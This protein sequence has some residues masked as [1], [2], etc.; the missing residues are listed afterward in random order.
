AVEALC[1]S[2][3]AVWALHPVLVATYAAD[4]GRTHLLS[5]TFSILALQAHLRGL[6]ARR[7]AGWFTA[8]VLLLAAAMLC[9]PI[10][11]W[12][13]VATGFHWLR[14]GPRAALTAPSTYVYL[15]IC[16]AFGWLT[17]ATSRESGL[18]EDVGLALSGDPLT[19]SLL[20]A[21]LYV[22]HIFRP[23]NLAT[24]YPPDIHTGWRHPL[25]WVGAAVVGASAAVVVLT[26][27]TERFRGVAVG[28]LWYWALLAPMLGFVGA[29]LAAAQDRYL[30]QPLIGALFAFGAAIAGWMRS[31]HCAR[32]A[33]RIWT[34]SG[35]LT[36]IALLLIPISREYAGDARGALR[37]AERVREIFPSDPRCE[38][39]LATAYMFAA[40]HP[41]GRSDA[42][43]LR[44]QAH[45]ALLRAGE[46]ADEHPE[47]FA[48]ATHRAWF[49]RDVS[50]R[51]Q[52][53][54]DTG[55]A[56]RFA[57][58]AAECEPDSPETLAR[59]AHAQRAAGRWD[60]ALLTYLR[61][62][63]N[64]PADAALR[65]KR[66]TEFGD[67]CMNI[68]NSPAEALARYRA[69]VET[70]A[71]PRRAIAGLARAELI[72]GD[73]ERGLEQIRRLLAADQ[74]DFEAQLLLAM[75]FGR[76]QQFAE[77]G[78]IYRKLI[79]IDPTNYEALRGFHETCAQFG[80]WRDAAFAWQTA[81]ERKPDN[82]AF[83]A[84]FIWAAACANEPAARDWADACLEKN[85]D[86]PFACFAQM[87]FAL[88]DA[89][90]DA[91]I[92]WTRRGIAGPS[93]PQAKESLRAER[94]LELMLRRD[95]IAPR[96]LVA[97]A[98]L[99]LDRGDLEQA[100][101]RLQ[102]FLETD[103]PANERAT[104]ESMLESLDSAGS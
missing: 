27:R 49:Y 64:P 14:R 68:Y 100:R 44:K 98:V 94:T 55:G 19:R 70:G 60:D 73:L 11:G 89:D 52:G 104:A 24:W 96:A 43:A 61:I 21:A 26:A 82:E 66:L 65:A 32:T 8:T 16:A 34:V 90:L 50:L 95:E 35:V 71:A 97:Q 3:A 25:V 87:L 1:W 15:A 37:R 101:L 20:A 42:E 28:V 81:V 9:K 59:L 31:D 22:E 53:F 29:R 85:P 13:A 23:I 83:R 103:P 10:A 54:D 12:F 45:Q 47:F 88:R 84:Y 40:D 48:G 80:K 72:A 2:L 36:A 5:A 58:R 75:Y 4:M 86:E 77:A 6:D 17:L 102:R 18:I 56:L 38:S 79:A 46:L 69:A 30:Y 93:R 7:A 99:L 62:E 91:A 74:N 67:L 63:E 76:K 51:L 78:A 57:L 92:E 39:M 33:G 41:P